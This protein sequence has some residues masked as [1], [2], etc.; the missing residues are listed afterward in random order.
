MIRPDGGEPE[1]RQRSTRVEAP[2]PAASHFL[3]HALAPAV[4]RTAVRVALV[5]GTVLTLINQGDALFG[6]GHVSLVKALLTY[7]IPYMVSTHGA[8]T[9]RM[10]LLG[11]CGT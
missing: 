7:T 4:V 11:S 1:G 8:V 3:N 9:A 5:V 2:K 6:Q 10:R